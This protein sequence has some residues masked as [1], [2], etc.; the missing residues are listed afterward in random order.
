M[1]V[2]KNM[3][4]NR[5]L[6][7]GCSGDNVDIPPE[8]LGSILYYTP[9]NIA[10]PIN[11]LPLKLNRLARIAILASPRIYEGF[12]YHNICHEL[13]PQNWRHILEHARPD[14]LLIESCLYDSCRAWPLSPY[15]PDYVTHM[16]NIAKTADRN[17]I[18]AI[19]WHTQ[20]S[21]ALDLYT[22]AMRAFSIVACADP[23]SISILHERGLNARLLPWAFAPE[24]FNPLT[25]FKFA[26]YPHILLF[27]GIARM[28]RFPHVR[29]QL[30]EFLPCDLRVIDT[31]MLIPP[32]NMQR[33]PEKDLA[34]CSGGCVSQK[35]VHEL[36]KTS[37]AYLDLEDSPGKSTPAQIWRSLEAAAC[38]CP[39]LR[40]GQEDSFLN[41]FTLPCTSTTD[42]KEKYASLKENGLLREKYGHLAWR[43]AHS[44]HTFAHRM[45]TIHKWIGLDKKAVETE[46]ASIVTPT[47]RPANVDHIISQYEQQTWIN[48][49]LIYVFNGNS[50]Q[51]PTLPA[52]PDIKLIHVP[53][54]Y[55]T[56]MVMN[57]GLMQASGKFVFKLDDDDLYGH[58]YVHD[59]MI[60]FREFNIVALGSTRAYFAFK[61]ENEAF[62]LNKRRPFQENIASCFGDVEYTI[63][64]FTGATVA[65]NK[66]H[67]LSS[68]YQEQA[69]A[70]ADVSF[71]YKNIFFKPTAPY[72]NTDRMNFCVLRGEP[73]EHTW[74]IS[75]NELRKMGNNETARIDDI[76][77]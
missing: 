72:I 63:S 48:K 4:K 13:S 51:L 73:N 66:E 39:V 74:A 60:Y 77:V 36:Y 56:G 6:R 16:H 59:R 8:A 71:L 47:M 69:F 21:E 3:A 53:A 65:V 42:A 19:F 12:S 2:R 38:R 20:G 7:F 32:Y 70:F 22:E 43:A 50:D 64:N 58:N 33:F 9:Q 41:E 37:T 26:E 11:A 52:R 68:G 75:K 1:I 10:R 24:Q 34:S 76:F 14:Y 27:D 25:N 17:G 55:S 62:Y 18:P 45:D 46:K 31:S 40:I 49:E 35:I 28:V 44:N 61:G 30:R 5:Q 23:R 54:E 15:S 29:K 57:A 67:A